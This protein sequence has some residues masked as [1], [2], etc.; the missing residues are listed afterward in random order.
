[1]DN[2]MKDRF[3][4]QMSFF[5]NL[6]AQGIEVEVPKSE[7]FDLIDKAAKGDVDA[8]AV[9]AEGYAKGTH[10]CEVNLAKARKWALYAAKKG[11]EKA[12]ALLAEMDR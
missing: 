11:S 5:D 8:C 10:D 3:M 4:S 6:K 2:N 9:L 1:M 12:A 7:K